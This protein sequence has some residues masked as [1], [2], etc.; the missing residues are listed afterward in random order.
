MTVVW[1][2]RSHFLINVLLGRDNQFVVGDPLPYQIIMPY[3]LLEPKR[4]GQK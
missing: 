3:A 2:H 1:K 4:E